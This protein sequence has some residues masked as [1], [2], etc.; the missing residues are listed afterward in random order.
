MIKIAVQFGLMVAIFISSFIILSKI[1][2]IKY[3]KLNDAAVKVD[4]KRIGNLLYKSIEKS[5]TII[6][7]DSLN[8]GL[9]QIKNAL[10]MANKIDAKAI[11]IH[12]IEKDEVN[13]FAMPDNH[14][15]IYNS[16]ILECEN[17]DEL[18]G[19][20]AHEIAHMQHHHVMKKLI[21]EVGITIVLSALGGNSNFTVLKK[22]FQN[23]SSTAYDRELETD[24]DLTA[25][26]YLLKSKV[27]PVS[28]AHFLEK[29]ATIESPLP[30][31]LNWLSTHPE[32]KDRAKLIYE[33]LK[34]DSTKF[35][36]L[37]LGK[38]WKTFQSYAEINSDTN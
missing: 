8:K 36:K 25:V 20:M 11:K 38:D 29:L 1:D 17:T 35:E 5:E 33:K 19:V 16:L 13:A 6:V 32:S 2:F 12:V 10:C 22:I 30:K 15:V 37:Q 27:N 14:L 7:D 21:K 26:Q 31:Q 4:E 34:S 18:A 28:F 3:F 9:E 24:A 23:L